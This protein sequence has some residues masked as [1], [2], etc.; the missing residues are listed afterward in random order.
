MAAVYPFVACDSRKLEA[1]DIFYD[2]AVFRNL[3][4]SVEL[5]RESMPGGWPVSRYTIWTSAEAEERFL[6]KGGS[7]AGMENISFILNWRE[8][9][10]AFLFVFGKE[11][12]SCKSIFCSLYSKWL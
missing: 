7:V 5:M 12:Q 1:V 3:V 10:L 8:V 11:N 2:E 9:V 6:C 4:K